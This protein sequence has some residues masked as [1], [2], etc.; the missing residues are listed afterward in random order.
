MANVLVLKGALAI[1]SKACHWTY[2]TCVVTTKEKEIN[3]ETPR[4]MNA[5]ITDH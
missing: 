4:E 2:V 5:K 3:K 1:L